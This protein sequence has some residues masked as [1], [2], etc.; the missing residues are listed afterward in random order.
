MR[1]KLNIITLGVKD[2]EASLAFYEKGLN[3]K[4]SKASQGDIVFFQMGGIVLAL[5]PHTKLADDVGLLP[6]RSEFSGVTIA[7]NTK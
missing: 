6:N 1:Q 5:Y 2:M 4:R 7:Y 3:W